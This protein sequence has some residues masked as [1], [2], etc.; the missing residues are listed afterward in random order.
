M[1]RLTVTD[2]GNGRK[3]ISWSS[4]GSDLPTIACLGDCGKEWAVQPADFIRYDRWRDA[5]V[6]K[7]EERDGGTDLPEHGYCKPCQDEA[8]ATATY[9]GGPDTDLLEMRTMEDERWVWNR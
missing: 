6:T 5:W 1:A 9:Y 3:A 7:D 2:L 4:Y 8:N